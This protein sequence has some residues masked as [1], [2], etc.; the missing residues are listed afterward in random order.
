[1][2]HAKAEHVLTEL[3]S[4]GF[5]QCEITCEEEADTDVDTA[6]QEYSVHVSCS[7]CEALCICGIATHERGCPNT[8]HDCQECGQ[9]Y[10]TREEAYA[11]CAPCEEDYE[12]EEE[13]A[14]DDD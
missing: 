8:P 6:D 2:K 5:D 10:R 14:Y 3:E 1:M 12:A 11:C 9:T 13:E 7:Q 4:R